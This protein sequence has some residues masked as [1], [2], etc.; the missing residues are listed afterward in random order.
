MPLLLKNGRVVQ[1]TPGKE[2]WLASE[3]PGPYTTARTI[4]SWKIVEAQVHVE[5]LA[6]TAT[7]LL[8]KIARGQ[9]SW[10]RR[11]LAPAAAQRLCDHGAMRRLLMAHCHAAL[12]A[13]SQAEA[14]AAPLQSPASL[15]VPATAHEMRLTVLVNWGGSGSQHTATTAPTAVAAAAT[16][17]PAPANSSEGAAECYEPNFDVQ[18]YVEPLPPLKTAPVPV[19]VR[20]RPPEAT[21][22]EGKDSKVIGRGTFCALCGHISLVSLESSYPIGWDTENANG[23]SFRSLVG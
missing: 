22:Y 11:P 13:Y 2:S 17:G 7:A 10:Q 21:M 19:M 20:R 14:K 9:D 5:R 23:P 18:V 8:Q 1:P 15:A 4:D 3:P 6:N 16:A 12:Q